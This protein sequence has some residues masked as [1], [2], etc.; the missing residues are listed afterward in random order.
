MSVYFLSPPPC[1]R[2][3]FSQPPHPAPYFL[4]PHSSAIPLSPRA[5]NILQ[6]IASNKENLPPT[7]QPQTFTN[8]T[9]LS[10]AGIRLKKNSDARKALNDIS[11]NAGSRSVDVGDETA[12]ITSTNYHDEDEEEEVICVY[13]DEL[14]INLESFVIHS[15]DKNIHTNTAALEEEEEVSER[16]STPTAMIRRKKIKDGKKKKSKK[17]KS[18]VKEEKIVNM[19]S[20]R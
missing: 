11:H 1:A 13:S 6:T 20:F 19:R 5:M 8:P 16:V 2:I 18:E 4:S 12:T 9:I 10:P 3:S 14:N 17:V 7:H 15:D